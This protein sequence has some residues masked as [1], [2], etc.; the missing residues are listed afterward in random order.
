MPVIFWVKK[1]LMGDAASA[2]MD[3]VAPELGRNDPL[4][5]KGHIQGTAYT[6]L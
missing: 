1:Y 2:A 4:R 3:G 5:K 6:H